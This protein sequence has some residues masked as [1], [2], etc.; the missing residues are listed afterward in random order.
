MRFSRP[1]R[2]SQDLAFVRMPNDRAH[3][4]ATE[5]EGLAEAGHRATGVARQDSR[6]R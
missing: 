5:A 1:R 6:C 3:G 2:L 4:Y